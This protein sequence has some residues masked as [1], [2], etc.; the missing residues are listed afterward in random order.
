MV[1]DGRSLIAINSFE[2]QPY[3]F[4]LGIT[5][6]SFVFEKEQDYDPRKRNDIFY[7]FN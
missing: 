4:R 6:Y 5:S 1:T 3:W 2:Q 7:S